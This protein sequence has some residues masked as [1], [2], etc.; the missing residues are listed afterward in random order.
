MAQRVQK[1]VLV[2]FENQA[3]ETKFFLS[4]AIYQY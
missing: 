1:V 2:L 4:K 3:R